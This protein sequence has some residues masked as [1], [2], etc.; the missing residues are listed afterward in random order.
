[1]LALPWDSGVLGNGV[2]SGVLD[3]SVT[4]GVLGTWDS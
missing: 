1:M 2:T 4:S 3:T